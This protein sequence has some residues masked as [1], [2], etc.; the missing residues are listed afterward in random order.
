MITLVDI[1]TALCWSWTAT[2]T[3][4]TT[5]LIHNATTSKNDR[6]L[7]IFAI[8]PLILAALSAWAGWQLQIGQNL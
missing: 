6:V 2:L 5:S 7:A 1:L 4:L 8:P 3:L